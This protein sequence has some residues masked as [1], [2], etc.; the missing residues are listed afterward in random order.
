MGGSLDESLKETIRERAG[1]V[2]EYCRIPQRLYPDATFH[3][4]HIRAKQHG[5]DDEPGNLALACHW[6]NLKKGPNL[7]SVDPETNRVMRLYNPRTD[8]WEAH[9]EV[10]ANG[11][12]VGLTAVGRA[13]M[14]LLEMNSEVRIAIRQ[15]Q[16]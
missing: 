13:T 7:S 16:K 3:V 2:C 1:H 9:F 4:E 12:I 8:Q 5:G 11:K 15:V 6:C 14:S 10:Q